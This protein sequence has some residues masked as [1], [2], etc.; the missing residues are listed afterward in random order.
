[1]IRH[2]C[3]QLY[4]QARYFL[5][6]LLICACSA[7]IF[8]CQD[9]EEIGAQPD[10]TVIQ[11]NITL[12][13]ASPVVLSIG[14]RASVEF[15]ITP[16]NLLPYT[17]D[18]ICRIELNIVDS[19]LYDAS[20]LVP[21]DNFRLVA[22]EP[23][24][25]DETKENRDG[26]YIAIIEDTKIAAEYDEMVAIVLNAEDA[27]GDTIHISSSPF[28]IKGGVRNGLPIVSIKTPN[29]EPIVSKEDY[30]TGSTISIINEDLSLA[31]Q[32][33]MKIKGRGNSTWQAPKKPYKMK[34]DNKQSLF[35][36]PK[37]KEW[38]LLA[39]YFDK[40]MVR[41][42]VA[43]W[44]AS[45]Y[46]H[47]DYVPKFHFVDLILNGRYNGTY[48]LGEQLKI[49]ESRVNVGNDG[50]LLEIDVKSSPTDITFRV[51]HISQ[52]INIKDPEVE[53]NDDNYNFIKDYVTRADAVLY[54]QA[55]LNEDDGYKSL[56]DMQSFVEW[57]LVMEI[58]KN[59]DAAFYT[60]SYM[61]LAR[62][63]KL[64]MGPLWDFDVSLGG[65][66]T[67]LWGNEYLNQPEGFHIKNA[68]WIARMFEDPEF[69]A[70][71]K[72]RF[73]S[74]YNNKSAII[75]HIDSIAGN[76]KLSAIANNKVWGGLCSCD[77]SDA[78]AESAYCEQVDY[79]KTWLSARFDWLKATYDAM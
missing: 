11:P 7:L 33:Q 44:M 42:D 73:D 38:I 4:S 76:N 2:I 45:C 66:P 46:G 75:A 67:E 49:A 69:V 30:I 39:N 28:E 31:F 9:Q 12:L 34:F 15:R 58:T 43:Y 35:G 21:H 63:G 27:N 16:S 17:T 25:D 57:Y 19:T 62:N 47:F 72:D 70:T 53:I 26:Q 65:F 68:S 79:L 41:S 40:P 10:V 48:Q 56:I 29:N 13:S 50:F 8:S 5:L 23:S 78:E 22:I 74:Y 51:P 54:S 60:S 6:A 18:S 59:C 1:M 36:D 37:D 14:T 77:A 61:N 71:V 52:P 55:W 24:Y 3:N 32:G 20:C 64:K